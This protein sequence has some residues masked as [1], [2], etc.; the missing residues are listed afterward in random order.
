MRKRS[1]PQT[2]AIPQAGAILAKAALRTAEALGLSQGDLAAVIGVS[3]AS[4]SRLKDGALSLS[5]KPFEL[6]A[7]LVRVFRS[8]DAIAAGDRDTSRAWMR[9]L[10]HDLN[11]VPADMLRDVAGLV[12]VMAYLD[13][14]RAPL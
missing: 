2:D 9:N 1:A 8:L 3:P 12:T 13:A 10:N 14:A 6:A 4:V 7:C 11:A 5:G